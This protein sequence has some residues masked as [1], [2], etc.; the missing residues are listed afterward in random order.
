MLSLKRLDI[1]CA[2]F[3]DPS[4]MLWPFKF[5]ENLHCSFSSVL[6]YH[7]PHTYTRVKSYGHLNLSWSSCWVSSVS[8]Y[9]LPES[10]ILVKCY[11][12]LNFLKAS[13]IHFLPSRDIMGLTQKRVKCYDHLNLPI[14]LCSV[15]SV[16]IY[17][18][19]ESEIRL[20]CYDI[21]ILREL[22]L[23]FSER[24]NISWASHTETSQKLWPFEFSESSML[25]FKRPDILCTRIRD[26][27][28]M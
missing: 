28:E 12:H 4:G 25:R 9:Y 7:R 23:F 19:L 5:L 16:L 15:S 17:Y 22:P 27:S 8:I 6:K 21:W 20:K 3:G 18:A 24:L 14:A 1:L 26:P 11:D 10:E 13:V 2:G